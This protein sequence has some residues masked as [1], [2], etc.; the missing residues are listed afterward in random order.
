MRRGV[1]N[2]VDVLHGNLIIRS[3]TDLYSTL[4]YSCSESPAPPGKSWVEKA[5]FGST[6]SF[7]PGLQAVAGEALSNYINCHL[8]LKWQ[9]VDMCLHTYWC[10]N[11]QLRGLISI[12]RNTTSNLARKPFWESAKD[13]YLRWCHDVT[14]FGWHRQLEKQ[15]LSHDK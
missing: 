10:S 2:K 14:N 8:T 1:A 15:V 13:A 5:R 4:C 9:R 3:V 7:V 11:L 6:G 12:V